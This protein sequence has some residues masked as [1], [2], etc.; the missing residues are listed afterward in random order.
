[1]GLLESVNGDLI[2]TTVAAISIM[3]MV[4]LNTLVCV[5]R[6]QIHTWIHNGDLINTTVAAISIMRTVILNTLVHVDRTGIHNGDLINTTV[7]AIS[8]MMMVI[9]NTLVRNIRSPAGIFGFE[10]RRWSW[11]QCWSGSRKDALDHA[12]EDST[13][14]SLLNPANN[15]AAPTCIW[16]SRWT[17]S[18]IFAIIVISTL[19]LLIVLMIIYTVAISS[20]NMARNMVGMSK[21]CRPK[22]EKKQQ[23][24]QYSNSPPRQYLTLKLGGIL[25]WIYIYILLQYRAI[26]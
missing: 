19:D 2:N 1:M 5:D 7:A 26:I 22:N 12:V 6:T 8:I 9:L 4:I 16:G 20:N 23:N 13:I 3:M 21:G 25:H 11:F 24:A 17:I 18:V 10:W 15:M 14:S